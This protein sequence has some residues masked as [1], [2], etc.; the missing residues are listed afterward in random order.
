MTEDCVFEN[1]NPAPDGERFE[2]QKAVR[3]FWEEFFASS[4]NAR[5]EAE[6]LVVSGDRAVLRWRY[7]WTESDGTPGHVRGV[8]V[9]RVQ[10]GKLAEKLAYVKG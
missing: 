7:D 8:D 9:L 3:R 10:D 1:T 6:E 2:G 5:F 4:P